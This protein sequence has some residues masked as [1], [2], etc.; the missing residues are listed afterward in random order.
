MFKLVEQGVHCYGQLQY[1][2]RLAKTLTNWQGLILNLDLDSPLEKLE[3][4]IDTK[5]DI[6]QDIGKFT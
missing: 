5:L 4:L 6:L 2:N 1:F 3:Q